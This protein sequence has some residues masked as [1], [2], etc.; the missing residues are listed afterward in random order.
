M[1]AVV[2][3]LVIMLAGCTTATPV[4]RAFPD[5]P[6]ALRE[7]CENLRTIDTTDKVAITEMLKVIVHNYGLYYECSARVDGWNEWYTEQKKIFDSAK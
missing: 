3:C 5:A 1:K 6:A 7:K 2:L 4:S